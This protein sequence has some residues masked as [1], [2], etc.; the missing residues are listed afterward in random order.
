MQILVESFARFLPGRLPGDTSGSRAA[1]TS[2]AVRAPRRLVFLALFA[3]ALWLGV[4]ACGR[5][6]PVA[7]VI[8]TERLRGPF[9]VAERRA[10]FGRSI[11]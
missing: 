10:L 7:G 8:V 4:A 3:C 1:R 9:D 11:D 5:P 6:Q 2:P